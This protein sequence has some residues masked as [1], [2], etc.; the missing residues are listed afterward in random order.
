MPTLLFL[1]VVLAV[2]GSVI[3]LVI[4]A[5]RRQPV[6]STVRVLAL[7]VLGYA[8]VWA[9][10]YGQRRDQAVAL[11]TPVCFDDWCATVTR[12]DTPAVLATTRP[13]GHFLVV[14]LA[15]ANHARGIAQKPS[16]PRV[17]LLDGQGHRWAYS[18][19][20]QQAL[21]QVRGFQLPLDQRLALH[22]TVA[23][24]LAFDVPRQARNLRVLIEEGPFITQLLLPQDQ[25]VFPVPE[26]RLAP[27]R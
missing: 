24:Q 2:L 23:T 11:G 15:L 22:Q 20:A 17:H 19:R 8:V 16:A 1:L 10:C 26:A 7:V 9:V 4:Q 27:T 14:Q 6:G 18:A 13:Q 25:A 5:V 12:L 3:R 21:Q